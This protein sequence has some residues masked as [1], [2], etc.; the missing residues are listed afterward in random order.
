VDN[1]EAKEKFYKEH[2]AWA[3][4]PDGR[5]IFADGAVDAEPDWGWGLLQPP[6]R[7]E[8]ERCKIIAEYSQI[9]AEASRDRFETFQMW[10][11]GTGRSLDEWK[12]LYTEQDKLDHLKRLRMIAKRDQSRWIAAKKA[13]EDATPFW[14]REA[15][16]ADIEAQARHQNFLDQVDQ[17]QL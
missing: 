3:R 1:V 9:V 12:T 11:K 13:L 5:I 4:T 16:Q 7:D 14:I 2:G 10:L 15:E 17:I 6:S 8:W